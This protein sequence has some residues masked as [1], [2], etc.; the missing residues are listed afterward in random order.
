MNKS[1][2]KQVLKPLIKEC[3]KE[4]IFESGVLSKVVAEVASGLTDSQVVL[5]SRKHTSSSPERQFV[6]SVR[7][8]HSGE[9]N[10]K[11]EEYKK[12]FAETVSKDSYGGVDLFEGTTPLQSAGVP[13]SG[14]KMGPMANIDPQDEGVNIDG[15]VKV[16]GRAWGKLARGK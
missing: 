2:L 15:L 7:N 1:E 10:Q 4:V 8:E 6:E 13:E 5:E 9:T 11:L 16:A 12:S 3:I 14:P